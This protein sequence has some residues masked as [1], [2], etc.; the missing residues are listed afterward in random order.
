MDAWS[1][2]PISLH[3]NRA[4]AIPTSA[5]PRKVT[6]P[7]IRSSVLLESWG[8][9]DRE[10]SPS[11]CPLTRKFAGEELSQGKNFFA[12]RR[13]GS[14][15]SAGAW[16]A[17]VT[18]LRRARALE[19]HQRR[20]R[21]GEVGSGIPRPGLACL[22]PGHRCPSAADTSCC[23]P[24]G[25]GGRRAAVPWQ[26]QRPPRSDG[27]RGR[28]RHN[29]G[30]RRSPQAPSRRS[31]PPVYRH[32]IRCYHRGR[33]GI[34]RGQRRSLGRRRRMAPGTDSSNR[35]RRAQG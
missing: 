1:G 17:G 11:C 15:W 20:R 21:T 28:P 31:R 5:K 24:R 19:G 23:L 16:R 35:R 6:W 18:R 26:P 30:C 27:K 9:I 34:P 25:T 33:R 10:R 29:C 32:T 4:C 7:F 12:G 13:V 22:Q 2:Y 14:Q 3:R 8:T